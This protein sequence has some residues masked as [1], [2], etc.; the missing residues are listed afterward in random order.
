MNKRDQGDTWFGLSTMQ[1]NEE[2]TWVD[3]SNLVFGNTFKTHPWHKTEPNRR[4]SSNE[5]C[6]RAAEH[7]AEW[8]D[9]PCSAEFGFACEGGIGGN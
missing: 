4:P 6:V 3:G 9:Y 5:M 2:F 7:T 1:N 8:K